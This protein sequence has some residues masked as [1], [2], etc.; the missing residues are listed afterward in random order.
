MREDVDISL[1]RIRQ[2]IDR[3][4]YAALLEIQKHN[5]MEQKS[6]EWVEQLE[7]LYVKSDNRLHRQRGRYSQS[8]SPQSS[9]PLLGRKCIDTL[10]TRSYIAVSYIWNPAPGED[11]KTGGYIVEL[12]DH[13]HRSSRRSTTV[14]D[15]VWDRVTKFATYI[16]C[17]YFWVDQE[18]IDQEDEDE[19]EI[20]IQSMD[21]VYSRSQHP[22]ALLS[23]AR[24][25]SGEQLD[26]LAEILSGSFIG[27]DEN[28][29]AQE[30]RLNPCMIGM[31]EKALDLLDLV[32]SDKWWN[33][34]WPFQEDYRAST[35]MTL[36]IPHDPSL[37]ARKRD[38]EGLL[39][40][41]LEGEL[42]VNSANF[43]QEA[44]QLCL[45]Y[46]NQRR[47]QGRLE[48]AVKRVLQR[49]GKYTVTL[50]DLRAEDSMYAV[51]RSMSPSI[52]ADVGARE[53]GRCVDRLAI[54]A[55]CCAYSVRLRT[56]TLQD[57]NYSLSLALLTLYLLNG[58]IL[59]NSGSSAAP[60]DNT[61]F[62]FLKAQSLDSFS[63]PTDH[64]QLTFIKSCRLIRVRLANEGIRTRGHLWE[65]G[66]TVRVRRRRRGVSWQFDSN[67]GLTGR[68]RWRLYQL[69]QELRDPWN[70]KQYEAED[71]SASLEEFLDRDEDGSGVDELS[72]SRR[73]QTWMAAE[74]ASAMWDERKILRL[75][76]LVEGPGDNQ[77]EYTGIFIYD[78]DR[79]SSGQYIFTA[80]WDGEE[81]EID[82][83]VSLEVEF[84]GRSRSD[85]PLLHAKRWVNGLIFFRN[86]RRQ[87]F[88]FAWP[89]S[90]TV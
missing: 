6:P 30:L 89:P 17:P 84:R 8:N 71:L 24:I 13:S 50:Q 12:R 69:V 88:V 1:R 52:F 63:P 62:D 80:S 32:T 60:L 75:G 85:R 81:V 66:P 41:V 65:L 33:R 7:C 29:A 16:D 18:C 73:F 86:H 87:D 37:E 40:G 57:G 10:S 44:S 55:N 31:V 35:R 67:S 3:P 77:S 23:A 20:A 45:A 70:R 4:I 68:Q 21:L 56:K 19:K 14:R 46:M 9:K 42:C 34:A 5:T 38:T 25:V 78:A 27:G 90:F 22:I 26:L 61:I 76:R 11:T 59:M 2:E 43:R 58:E 36:L 82:K 83:H 79:A 47:R 72:F 74:V 15:V 48:E 54:V 28:T 53:A 51:R 64:Q 49:A 39:F